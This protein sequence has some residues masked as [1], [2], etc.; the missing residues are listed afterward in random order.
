MIYEPLYKSNVRW[1]ST[2][3]LSQPLSII[4]YSLLH[5]RKNA[6]RVCMEKNDTPIKLYLIHDTTNKND[7]DDVIFEKPSERAD[8]TYMTRNRKG[9]RKL[10]FESVR[11]F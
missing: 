5:K 11:N 10:I 8:Y 9:N 7:K 2:I 6:C 4:P 1:F 3:I